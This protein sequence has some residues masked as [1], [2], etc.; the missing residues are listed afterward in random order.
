MITGVGANGLGE[1]VMGADMIVQIE[2]LQRDSSLTPGQR[3]AR[4]MDIIGNAMLQ[5][6]IAVGEAVVARGRATDL[7]ARSRSGGPAPD[8][9]TSGPELVRETG[10]AGRTVERRRAS[11]GQDHRGGDPR[12]GA[13]GVAP[14]LPHVRSDQPPQHPA[15]G[16]R[17]PALEDLL[18]TRLR[19]GVVVYP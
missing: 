7:D 1:F 15:R 11:P 16:H 5:A 12:R 10:H 14:R 18:G 17:R 9:A 4:V 2:A 3:A 8:A 19:P 13:A 6:G